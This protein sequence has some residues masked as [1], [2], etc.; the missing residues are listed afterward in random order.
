MSARQIKPIGNRILVCPLR[1]PEKSAGGLHL[2]EQWQQPTGHGIVLSVGSEVKEIKAGDRVVYSWI[3]GR[4]VEHA[5]Q[6]TRLLDERE[7]LAII[8]EEK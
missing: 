8:A 1:P 6:M 2:P 4:D 7:V 3:N 5:G